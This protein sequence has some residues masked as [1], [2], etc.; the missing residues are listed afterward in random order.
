MRAFVAAEL[1]RLDRPDLIDD[2]LLVATELAANAV[3]HAGGLRGVRVDHVPGGIRIGVDDPTRL[4]PVLG[5]ASDWALRMVQK[6]ILY[7]VPET[8][9]V[10]RGL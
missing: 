1:A 8:T 5:F 7:W 9:G 2:A 10:L 6:R 4:R 3:L